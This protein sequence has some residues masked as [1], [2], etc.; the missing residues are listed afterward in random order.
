MKI[1]YAI[2]SQIL[3]N[4]ERSA[5]MDRQF[6]LNSMPRA[7]LRFAARICLDDWKGIQASRVRVHLFTGQ[8][9][10]ENEEVCTGKETALWEAYDLV[11]LDS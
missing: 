1:I 4:V 9:L 3:S 5:P 2:L 11:P 10:N 7:R 6:N 8:L